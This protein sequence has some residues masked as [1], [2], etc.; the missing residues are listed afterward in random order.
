MTLSLVNSI[1]E[2]GVRLYSE[3]ESSNN[4]WQFVDRKLH[5]IQASDQPFTEFADVRYRAYS[6]LIKLGVIDEKQQPSW[7]ELLDCIN[8]MLDRKKV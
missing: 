7:N 4:V 6:Q 3:G 2:T 1:V 8:S 5:Q